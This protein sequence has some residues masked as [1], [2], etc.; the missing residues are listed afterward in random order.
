M[1]DMMP[2]IKKRRPEQQ[3]RLLISNIK[4]IQKDLENGSIIVFEQERIRVRSLP[5]N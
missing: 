2:Y 3:I 5:L 4:S 1:L